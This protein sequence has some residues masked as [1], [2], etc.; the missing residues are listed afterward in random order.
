MRR[1]KHVRVARMVVEA[2]GMNVAARSSGLKG[3]GGPRQ[4]DPQRSC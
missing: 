4:Y 1:Y 2:F 3:A